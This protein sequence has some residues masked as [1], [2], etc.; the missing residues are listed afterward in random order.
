MTYRLVAAQAWPWYILWPGV[1]CAPFHYAI[2]MDFI[3][4]TSRTGFTALLPEEGL[5][6]G[7][8]AAGCQQ[9]MVEAV[10]CS[11]LLKWK[12]YFPFFVN[13]HSMSCS[14]VNIW[15]FMI[16]VATRMLKNSICEAAS[17]HCV[18]WWWR[19]LF[20]L[21]VTFHFRTQ[22]CDDERTVI[23]DSKVVGTPME[24]VIGNMFKLDIWETLLSSMRIG[25]VAEFWCDTI[26]S[27]KNF[28]FSI[29]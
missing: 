21:Q 4:L 22:L 8:N 3:F 10:N 29:I 23:D 12:S 16:S 19:V 13:A 2:F 25:E 20:L 1:R 27:A 28:F 26:V 5:W 17:E 11:L 6:S 9:R 7:A 15:V 24:V 18:T 14:S